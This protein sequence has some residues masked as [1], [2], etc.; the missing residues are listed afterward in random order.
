MQLC[1]FEEFVVVV[2]CVVETFIFSI[3]VGRFVFFVLTPENRC[4]NC[5][6]SYLFSLSEDQFPVSGGQAK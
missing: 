2:V 6:L 4:K 3:C 5:C 1:I